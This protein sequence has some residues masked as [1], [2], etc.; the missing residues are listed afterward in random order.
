MMFNI[1]LTIKPYVSGMTLNAQF[2]YNH[3]GGIMVSVLAQGVVD[4]GFESGTGQTK[5][6]ELGICCFTRTIA[7]SYMLK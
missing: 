2:L 6:Y 4:R 1:T 5:V 7:S 3:I